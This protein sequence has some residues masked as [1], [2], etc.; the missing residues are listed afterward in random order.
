MIPIESTMLNSIMYGQYGNLGATIRFLGRGLGDF[1]NKY[2]QSHFLV[3][4]KMH[5]NFSGNKFLSE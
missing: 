3:N 2:L 5:H 4:K 1:L